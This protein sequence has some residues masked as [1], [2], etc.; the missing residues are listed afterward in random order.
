[1]KLTCQKEI[2]L[3]GLNLVSKAVSNKSSMPILECVLLEADQNGFRLTANDM[4]MGIRTSYLEAN[5]L[6]PGKV[7]ITAKFL[8]DIVRHLPA[9]FVSIQTDSNHVTQIKSAK[10]EFNVLAKDAYE[11]PELP[12]VEKHN[13]YEIFSVDFKNMIRQ[14]IFSVSTDESK[15]TF[16]GEL[17]DIQDNNLN[18]VAVDGFR[19]SN[20][21]AKLFYSS[22]DSKVIAP[23]KTLNEI[24]KILP[25]GPNDKV[26]FY[27][28]DKHALFETEKCIVVSRL[29]EGEF[30]NYEQV[31]TD[32]YNIKVTLNRVNFIDCLERSSLI[33]IKK[34]PIKIKIE[35]DLLIVSSNSEIGATY[36][37]VSADVEGGAL[38]IAFNPRYLIDALKVIDEEDVCIYFTTALS[39]CTIIGNGATGHRYLVLP[40]RLRN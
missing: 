15:A 17:L 13:R 1:M 26:N 9:D 29:I 22:G 11:Y 27:F 2:L 20:R 32:D 37:E 4:E 28:T 24:S 40:L 6:E 35:S 25:G 3:E 30:M 34:N 38:E 21:S 14:T 7:C 12:D 36:E 23:Y 18:I 10:S 33:D 31:F 8:M 16:T 19:V 39:A 5:V